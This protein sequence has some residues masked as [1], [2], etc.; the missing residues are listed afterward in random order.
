MKLVPITGGAVPSLLNT[1]FNNLSPDAPVFI[2]ILVLTDGSHA[3]Y[4]ATE[5]YG[6]A[7]GPHL[8]VHPE[9]RNRTS[10][11]EVSNIFKELYIPMMKARGAKYLVTN[12]D[13]NDRGTTNF[14]E[15][16]GFA[17]KKVVLAEYAL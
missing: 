9:H 15:K 6:L 3:G 12:C 1:F 14:L 5:D 7:G 8:F 11:T 17:I 16:V 2:H 4:V 13:Q 10:L